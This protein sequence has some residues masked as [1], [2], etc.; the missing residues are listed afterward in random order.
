MKVERS[1][2]VGARDSQAGRPQLRVIS[3]HLHGRFQKMK[4]KDTCV[5]PQ[6][7]GAVS[8]STK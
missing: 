1:G 8:T 5:E 2:T 6:Q 7:H 3:I 4:G